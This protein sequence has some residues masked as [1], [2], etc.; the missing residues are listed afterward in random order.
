[1]L[2]STLQFLEE[3]AARKAKLSSRGKNGLSPYSPESIS[4]TR[5]ITD[6]FSPLPVDDYHYL[7]ETTNPNSSYPQTPSSTAVMRTLP[8]SILGGAQYN[9]DPNNP[10]ALIKSYRKDT[11]EMA[12]NIRGGLAGYAIEVD[13]K[14]PLWAGGADTEQNKAP[15]TIEEHE[16]KTKVDAVMRTLYYAGK[17]NLNSARIGM[18]NWKLVDTQK[19]PKLI[20][21]GKRAGEL[22]EDDNKSLEI[23]QK[24]KAQWDKPKE[25]K[26]TLKGF[27]D[28]VKKN[29]WSRGVQ[30]AI[31]A[32]TFGIVPKNT[33]A[34]D[35]GMEKQVAIAEG[36][37]ELI[38]TLVGF[39]KVAKGLEFSAKALKLDGLAS[40]WVQSS[41]LMRGSEYT[42]GGGKISISPDLKVK[43]LKNTGIFA[44]TGQ[45]AETFDQAYN[46][47]YDEYGEIDSK[48]MK[49]FLAD[50]TMGSI[51]S[52]PGKTLATYASIGAA[53]YT[54]DKLEGA[55]NEGALLNSAIM[56][57]MHK[58]GQKGR[59]AEIQNKATTAALK[60]RIDNYNEKPLG[61]KVN[62]RT[63]EEFTQDQLLQQYKPGSIKF[64]VEELSLRDQEIFKKID[65][66][67]ELRS[68]G[69]T[70]LSKREIID[71]KEAVVTS[72]RQLY[73]S[74]LG[75]EKG[76]LEDAADLKSMYRR[77]SASKKAPE[78]GLSEG[79]RTI[80]INN[81]EQIFDYGNGTL[82]SPRAKFQKDNA[83]KLVSGDIEVTGGGLMQNAGK[84]ILKAEQAGTR[85]GDKAIIVPVEKS[86]L[87]MG[88]I[89]AGLP[90]GAAH[91]DPANV[92]AVYIP[93]EGNFVYVGTLASYE[94]SGMRKFDFKDSYKGIREI[95]PFVNKD[96]ILNA[97]RETN[98]PYAVAE[99]THI[100]AAGKK[101]G[102]PS[103][104]L[105]FSPESYSVHLAKGKVRQE[106]KYTEL[107]RMAQDIYA[108]PES[109]RGGLNKRS[110]TTLDN[111][112]SLSEAAKKRLGTKTREVYEVGWEYAMKKVNEVVR[113]GDLAEVKKIVEDTVG[114]I[115][116]TFT[117]K[118]LI[119]QG[120]VSIGDLLRILKVS[121]G[122]E[123]SAHQKALFMKA[124]LPETPK[125]SLKTSSLSLAK[126]LISKKKAIVKEFPEIKEAFKSSDK[127][128]RKEKTMSPKEN[129]KEIKRLTAEIDSKNR[130][131]TEKKD[132]S[133]VIVKEGK[134]LSKRE[135]LKKSKDLVTEK[136]GKPAEV[137]I[138]GKSKESLNKKE[139]AIEVTEVVNKGVK[140]PRN[141][142]SKKSAEI[143]EKKDFIEKTKQEEVV[144]SVK[145]DRLKKSQKIVD[146]ILKDK[147]ISEV[148]HLP[149]KPLGKNS[150]KVTQ[151]KELTKEL[152]KEKV[153]DFKESPVITP[154][155]KKVTT[156]DALRAL[157]GLEVPKETKAA[158]KKTVM[159]RF[160]ELIKSGKEELK[161]IKE[162]LKEEAQTKKDLAEATRLEKEKIDVE[163]DRSIVEAEAKQSQIDKDEE[164]SLTSYEK[165]INRGLG[166]A[167][168]NKIL[169]LRDV[170][171]RGEARSLNARRKKFTRENLTKV[172][173]RLY[174]KHGG[175]EDSKSMGKAFEEFATS[176]S[177]DLREMGAKDTLRN[178]RNKAALLHH[179]D[180]MVKGRPM[181][182]VR[183]VGGKMEKVEG[184]PEPGSALQD[185]IEREFGTNTKIDIAYIDDGGS[186]FSRIK[187][188]KGDKSP[189]END[190]VK[191]IFKAVNEDPASEYFT[192]G[193]SDKDPHTIM[194]FK[195][196]KRMENH[197]DQEIK[198][199]K[200]GENRY[201]GKGE[202]LESFTSH[203]KQFRVFMVD[204]LGFNKEEG[205]AK[206]LKRLKVL[207]A[208]KSQ[209]NERG[210]IY[211]E[212]IFKSPS[213]GEFLSTLTPQEKKAFLYDIRKEDQ[214]TIDKMAIFNGQLWGHAET[215]NSW[216]AGQGMYGY[217]NRVKPYISHYVKTPEGSK[218]VLQKGD[219]SVMDDYHLRFFE[220]LARKQDPE[221]KGF[222][223]KDIISFDENL[224][225]GKDFQ[226]GKEG[227]IFRVLDLPSEA[228]RLGFE[229]RLESGGSL[230]NSVFSL[231]RNSDNLNGVLG[232]IFKTVIDNYTKLVSELEMSK[233]GDEVKALF[234]KYKMTEHLYEH[235]PAATR[236]KLDNGAGVNLLNK[237][238][239]RALK[240]AFI[241][242]IDKG[243]FLKNKSMHATLSTDIGVNKGK[244][245]M[246]PHG[247]GKDRQLGEIGMSKAALT[248]MLGHPP[249]NG[250]EYQVLT[251][252]YPS[253]N[254]TSASMNKVVI[255]D[256]DGLPR[257]QRI[258]SLETDRVVLNH[259]DVLASKQADTD[260]DTVHIF[261]L[262]EE[263][264]LPLKLGKNIE[265]ERSQQKALVPSPMTK[266]PSVPATPE[267]AYEQT[268]NMMLGSAGIKQTA[269][270]RRVQEALNDA[271]ATIRVVNRKGTKVVEFVCE[272]SKSPLF[273]YETK[274]PFKGEKEIESSYG[275]EEQQYVTDLLQKSV[276]SATFENLS[277]EMPNG[278]FDDAVLI[279]RVLKD[280]KGEEVDTDVI[281]AFNSYLK[282][283]QTPYQ[284][285]D[286][287]E[288]SADVYDM[289]GKSNEW[290]DKIVAAGGK[291][292]PV[293]TLLSFF[294]GK[295]PLRR[296]SG[297]DNHFDGETYF[298]ETQ[299]GMD[300]AGRKA[301]MEKYKGI[302][303]I[304]DGAYSGNLKMKANENID[305][306]EVVS[307]VKE[308]RKASS[309]YNDVYGKRKREEITFE[310]ASAENK[311]IRDRIQQ[312]WEDRKADYNQDERDAIS[313]YLTTAHDANLSMS[314]NPTYFEKNMR[315]NLYY[316]YRLEDIFNEASPKMSRIYNEAVEAFRV[317][318]TQK[319]AIE[320]VKSSDEGATVRRSDWNAGN[321]APE[322]N[323]STRELSQEESI[324]LLQSRNEAFKGAA[325]TVREILNGSKAP[326]TA[327]REEKIMEAAQKAKDYLLRRGIIKPGKKYSPAE[328]KD[329]YLRT[330]EQEA[331]K[332]PEYRASAEAQRTVDEH[333]NLVQTRKQKD[334]K[335]I[336]QQPF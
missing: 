120:K 184:L 21:Q 172:A 62:P 309:G 229:S 256:A 141:E 117:T 47:Q 87:Y 294:K 286:K 83:V 37:G 291:L 266:F 257:D 203:G 98:T 64:T 274:S 236:R 316:L 113:R 335:N 74:G 173:K 165:G 334:K 160:K 180:Y 273:S 36:A 200:E 238:I 314:N 35:P 163:M 227:D 11:P 107:A 222:G 219:M 190:K 155:G 114:I 292:G 185:A 277:K 258:T 68:Q 189:T 42:I 319:G 14:M 321:L 28:E 17:I 102:R 182:K 212:Y 48:R 284:I 30:A 39:G 216:T 27:W 127:I 237:P 29:P 288:T 276:D 199:L 325:K 324:A 1:M 3:E 100:S 254:K 253:V 327:P 326:S 106:G 328:L 295:T 264:G 60:Y 170:G 147:N 88:K 244:F 280:L 40:K 240:N 122:Q 242:E 191:E 245:L 159:G 211:K 171:K 149:E 201:I 233:G 115:P 123:R 125:T 46:P 323:V 97:M 215:I 118:K 57:G 96:S 157:S 195:R 43:V 77:E 119:K 80:L 10:N 16:K 239:Q 249:E 86:E 228:I 93:V 164:A 230:G 196:S 84:G 140:T 20:S 150:V 252:R 41:K 279:R 139:K 302:F 231:F 143:L 61:I 221:F 177:N 78:P 333:N 271:G 124:A 205:I 234:K 174:V 224:K 281:R 161:S 260:G 91:G 18:M 305:R 38:G 112:A 306:N 262:G 4:T 145:V 94:R 121:E 331:M 210:E 166:S 250:K 265:T 301:V 12:D 329:L 69:E 31:S 109:L 308:V 23:A 9:F 232:K 290:S 85:I 108:G 126:K 158:I 168:D 181:T 206:V 336:P 311:E 25:A 318:K 73:K 188:D 19:A 153:I 246:P 197:F 146:N 209:I 67:S 194:L 58:M 322:E 50:V 5:K 303:E 105:S 204:V 178:P 51:I 285:K 176:V 33:D 101:S 243:G 52:I 49:R 267:S 131:G 22:S 144:R 179:F 142:A 8:D 226:T 217:R 66:Y 169:E 82:T 332:N 154:S 255:L 312:T 167:F 272:G 213:Y 70:P 129:L 268:Q 220:G 135:T 45:V 225:V 7:G 293:Q 270:F 330:K 248:K 307:F 128:I 136:E 269:S 313:F 187:T 89:D 223:K 81:K 278:I 320:E 110:Q 282:E 13:H 134:P 162:S 99:I 54:F 297:H 193:S 130:K 156:K 202:K 304:E 63:G 32:T 299:G 186:K 55:S 111:I 175:K 72:S 247:K 283:F 24:V 44:A 208:H 218:L 296:T 76:I 92:G 207:D 79:M 287:A 137:I 75:E 138:A 2:D 26:V 298:R 214:P 241:K 315:N 263:G 53:T 6:R 71:A 133:G 56:V 152:L 148:S 34:V 251:V 259:Q 198:N 192:F 59:D 104:G 65:A 116:N 103:L 289:I 300:Q 275:R 261:L 317:G 15:L 151:A 95:D 310:E 183:L 132:T 235:L 90:L